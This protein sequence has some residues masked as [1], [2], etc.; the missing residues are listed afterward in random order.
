MKA[1]R[2]WIADDGR[3]MTKGAERII[4]SLADVMEA[5]AEVRAFRYCP[6]PDEAKRLAADDKLFK[7]EATAESV[8]KEVTG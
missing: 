8:I 7:A 3:L 4:L 5:V 2:D 1:L 6:V